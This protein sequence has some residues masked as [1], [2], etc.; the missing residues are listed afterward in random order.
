MNQVGL[1]TNK[2][3]A[4]IVP[5]HNEEV[6]IINTIKSILQIIDASDIYVVSDGSTDQTASIA[7]KLIPNVLELFPNV[8]KATALNTA[9]KTFNLVQNYDFIMPVDADCRV[10]SNFLNEV[11]P[12]FDKDINHSLA[13]VV[14]KVIGQNHN[15]VTAYRIWEYEV[16]QNIHKSAQAHLNTIIVCPGPSTIYRSEIFAKHEIPTGTLTEDMDF[17]FLIHRN[18]LGKIY[19]CG[20]AIVT[21]QDPKNLRDFIKQNDRW[22]TG[23]WQCIKKHN[24]PWGGQPLD[25]EIAFLATEGLFNGALVL[26]LI[27]LLPFILLT[28][29][30][31]LLWPFLFDLFLFIIPTMSMASKQRRSWGIFKYFFT[32][33]LL[34]FVTSLIFLKSFIKIVIGSDLKMGWN[35]IARYNFHSQDL[36]SESLI[37]TIFSRGK[38]YL[39]VNH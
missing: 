39:W 3:V 33:Y 5:A 15:W 26:V 4:F 7:R 17:T 2:R 31:Q 16:A 38:E 20:K 36:N 27:G 22:H 32:F 21:T 28:N 11:L 25:A 23:F 1:T 19:Y 14:G 13:C 30:I 34:R 18:K 12:I 8:G 35:K 37:R 6:V 24:A 10:D 29:P 9:I